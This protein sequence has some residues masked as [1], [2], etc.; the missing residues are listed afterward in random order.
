MTIDGVTSL[1]EV[2]I[3]IFFSELRSIIVL[4]TSLAEVWIEIEDI[5]NLQLDKFSH[6]P[7][8]SVD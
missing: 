6:F 1:A 7:R 3:E 8:G 2:W 4:V 5:G